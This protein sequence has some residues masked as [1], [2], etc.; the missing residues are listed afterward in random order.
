MTK[1][2]SYEAET[3]KH[4]LWVLAPSTQVSYF[5]SSEMLTPTHPEPCSV[6]FCSPL[7]LSSHLW[8]PV[9]FLYGIK[10]CGTTEFVLL[11]WQACGDK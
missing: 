3:S 9:L 7:L 10:H 1:S 4:S 5:T 8:S 2:D 6:S 11:N